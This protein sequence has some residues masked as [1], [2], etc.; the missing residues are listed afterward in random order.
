M[1]SSLQADPHFPVAE[2]STVVGLLGFGEV[3]QILADDLQRVP[4]ISV[5]AYDLLFDSATSMQSREV[6]AREHVVAATD[7]ADLAKSCDFIIS[8]VT[9]AQNIVATRSISLH[10]RSG[11]YIL[12]LNSVSPDTKRACSAIITSA[13]GRYVEATLMGPIAPMR[14]ASPILLGGPH[15]AEFTSLAP[16][17]GFDKVSFFSAE[18]GPASAAKLCR[19]VIVKGLEALVMES[20]LTASHYGVERQVLGSLRN[21]M[22]LPNWPGFS[23]YL[24]GRSVEH[25]KRRAEEMREAASTVAAAGIEP[26]MSYAC[27]ARQEWASEF[28]ASLRQEEIQAMVHSIRSA[29]KS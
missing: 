11:T 24:I 16:K 17:L 22:D 14:S 13:G 12:D 23:R 21:I 18:V 8:C 15:A 1:D 2:N 19:S 25:G 20:L 7:A 3:G 26:L 9:A 29:M 10:L 28:V 6:K 4:D 5:R 27:A